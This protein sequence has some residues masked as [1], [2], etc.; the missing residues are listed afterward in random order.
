M[1]VVLCNGVFDLLHVAHIRHLQEA[2]TLGGRLVVAI[3]RDAHIGKPGR[4]IVPEHERLEL[5][6]ALRCVH[7]AQ[8]CKDSIEALKYWKPQVFCKGNDYRKKGLLDEEI[9]YCARH[10]IEIVHTR[11]N[12][13]TTTGIIERIER[14]TCVS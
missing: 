13:Q 11:H 7:E 5:I 1:R 12:P 9:S 14:L 2:A 3:T 4:P 10:G 6:R 8:L